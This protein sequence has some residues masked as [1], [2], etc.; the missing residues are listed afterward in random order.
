VLVAGV[1][2]GSPARRAGLLP[3]DL[4]V[5]VDGEPLPDV[6]TLHRAL[7]EVTIGHPLLFRVVRLTSL[8]ELEVTPERAGA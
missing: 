1:E 6:D 8:K 2:P 3:G 4:I 5:A 7:T